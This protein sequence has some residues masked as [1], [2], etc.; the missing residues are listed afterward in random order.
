M[1]DQQVQPAEA[2]AATRA[3]HAAQM[4]GSHNAGS[5]RTA[6][7][8]IAPAALVERLCRLAEQYGVELELPSPDAPVEFADA[9]DA[10]GRL[11]EC[12]ESPDAD[13]DPRTARTELR[14]IER[15]L[16]EAR[17]LGRDALLTRLR[18]TVGL[19]Q[20]IDSTAVLLQQ[21][22]ASLSHLG[23]D[24]TMIS[25]VDN[26]LWSTE[27]IYVGTDVAWADE[28]LE[29]ARG[30]ARGIA[31]SP[32]EAE[33]VRRARPIIVPDVRSLSADTPIADAVGARSYAIAPIV[34]NR[35][36]IGIVHADRHYQGR[37]PDDTDREVLACFAEGL[38][39]AL[40]RAA[41]VERLSTLQAE[42]DRLTSVLAAPA[43]RSWSAATETESEDRTTARPDPADNVLTRRE[44]EVLQWLAAGE[45]N[46]GI[47]RRMTI[48]VGTVKYHVANILRKLEVSNRA[49]AVARW[50]RHRG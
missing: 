19:L 32:V 9:L 16:Q 7:W 50:S 15:A 33:V 49:E 12:C 37:V 29:Q 38:G 30:R 35:S 40:T 14:S 42:L 25:R 5:A 31:E 24:R 20:G 8:R 17:I 6:H 23:F 45:T 43:G 47:A 39:Q 26:D 48:G 18:E 41:V 13:A 28:L 2:D 1:S 36:V 3:V 4:V 34:A 21:A 11:W 10:A 27:A 46:A 22:A 44:V